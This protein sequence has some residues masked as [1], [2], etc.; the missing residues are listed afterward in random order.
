MSHDREGKG[1]N[2]S[3]QSDTEEREYWR[4]LFG[5]LAFGVVVVLVVSGVTINCLAG[6]EGRGTIGD[7][8]GVANALFSGLAFAGLIVTIL[9]QR[10]ELKLQ[11]K[12]IGHNRVEFEKSAA[13]QQELVQ[14]AKQENDDRQNRECRAAT[15][16]L[17]EWK[18]VANPV[19]KIHGDEVR[20]KFCASSKSRIATNSKIEV[21]ESQR[22]IDIRPH[23][24]LVL[25]EGEKLEISVRA[26][27]SE[28]SGEI[29]ATPEFVFL[30]HYV[31][32]NGC[33]RRQKFRLVSGS[34]N[35]YCEDLGFMVGY[36]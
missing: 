20:W 12:E 24:R 36:P 7:M 23:E 26:K 28:H 3:D 8:F 14:L 25:Y 9:M 32:A 6:E 35:I 29:P 33:N 16:F 11:R 22:P 21:V 15:L 13:A 30:L 31:D 19:A 34:H 5:A 2:P 1:L 27:I 10:K 18:I 4:W 17:D